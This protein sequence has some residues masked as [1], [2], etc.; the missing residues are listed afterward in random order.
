MEKK[1]WQ[2][3]GELNQ[4]EGFQQTA[5]KE[6]KEELLPLEDLDDK[7]LLDAKTP[8]RDFLKYLGFSTAAATLAASCEMPVRH[9]V[10]YLQKPDNLTP[11]VANHYAS[12]CINEG[13]VTSV[14]V[15]QR[16]GRP[17]KIEGNEKSSITKG[18][19][20]AS[21]Q[22]SVLDL[23]DTTRLRYPMQKA[24]GDFKEVTTFEAF[25]KI[26]A[27][28]MSGLGGKPVVL[29]TSTINSPTTLQIIS[30]F[31]AK[32]AGSRHIQY[33]AVSYS[34]MLLANESSYGKRALPS[35]HFENAKV[36]VSIGAD[37]LG[38]WL[39]PVE[40]ASQYAETRRITG[41]K[42]A[43]SQHIHFEST[44]SL[45]GS[46]ADDRF[47]HKPSEKTAIA[48]SL[49]AK[50]GGAV[51]AP[52]I[53]D[54]DLN[55]GIEKAAAALNANKG[56]ALVVCGSND[57]NLQV[58]V[59]AINEAIG[60][61]GKTINHAVTSNYRAGIDADMV[62]LVTEMNAGAVGALLVYATNPVYTYYDSKKFVEGLAKVPVS[63][64]FNATMNET[65][66]LCKYSIPSHHWLESW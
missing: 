43:M 16:D 57:V 10:P 56:A 36:I 31:L 62:Q 18:G 14:I 59:N 35:Y 8:R 32:N 6:F 25:D 65:T 61:N 41:E 51:T 50:L 11:G 19:T 3:F 46:N 47:I 22:A 34:G 23:Y 30:E 45:T 63:I 64:S 49:L 40:F 17:I 15:K 39:S 53:S 48:L 44:L 7:G 29:L 42:P 12:T 4:S 38:T 24:G 28:A 9:V 20:S 58:I 27:D 54:A 1:Y 33:D 60:A 55:K 37:F 5:E 66:E 2:N 26:V 13:D 52:A 21:V